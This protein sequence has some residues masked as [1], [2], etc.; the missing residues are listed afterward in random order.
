M[1]GYGRVFGAV[2]V[3]T[4]L[5]GCSTSAQ[6]GA[7]DDA[8]VAEALS[9]RDVWGVR[10]VQDC[11]DWVQGEGIRNANRVRF[12]YNESTGELRTWP[13]EPFTR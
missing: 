13:I 9:A 8:A 12:L 4:V 5:G 10:H 6:P 11:G 2:L 7:D 3:S 1:R